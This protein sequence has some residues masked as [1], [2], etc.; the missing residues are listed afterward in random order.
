MPPPCPA[1]PRDC[2]TMILDFA[3]IHVHKK[4][5]YARSVASGNQL[6]V[7]QCAWGPIGFVQDGSLKKDADKHILQFLATT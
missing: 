5:S 7:C 4:R 6:C 2:N 3:C 1:Q